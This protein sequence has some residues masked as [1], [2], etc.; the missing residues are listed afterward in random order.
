MQTFELHFNPKKRDDLFLT[1]FAYTPADV[2]E[3]RLGNLYVVGELAQAMPQNSHF[4]TNLSLAMFSLKQRCLFQASIFD[5]LR[6]PYL[7][8]YGKI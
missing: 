6:L 8:N 2:Y 3:K 4:L 5:N 7:V 1:S